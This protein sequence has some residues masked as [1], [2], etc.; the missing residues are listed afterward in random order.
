[1]KSTKILSI[2][3]ALA[4]TVVM[5]AGTAL[6]ASNA[7]R[8]TYISGKAYKARKKTGP[9]ISIRRNQSVYAGYYIKT[10]GNAKVELTM[11]DKSKVRIAPGSVLYLSSARFSKGVRNY[12][13]RLESGRVYTRA[14]PS[15]NKK[16][17]FIVRTGGAV[18]GIRG[19]SFNTI[20]LPDGGTRVKCFEGKVWV[21]TWTDYARRFLSEDQEVPTTG[22]LDAPVVPGPEEVTEE[23]WVR[24]AGAMMSVTVGADGNVQDPQQFAEDDSDDWED[25]N[26]KRDGI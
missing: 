23:E 18:A 21:S 25:W 19:T 13:A 15:S 17:R 16:D 3:V 6:T 1:M 26:K 12:E 22:S 4:L 7:A 10:T 8:V 20:L 2:V 24:I 11:P 14:R 5:F 9:W